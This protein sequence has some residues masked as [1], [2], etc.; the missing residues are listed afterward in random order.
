MD[1]V[2][3]GDRPAVLY[4]TNGSELMRVGGNALR[5]SAI[6]EALHRCA[7][8]TR[9]RVRCVDEEDC[10]H[11]APAEP[12][13]ASG[14]GQD[15]AF[16]NAYCSVAGQQ[17]RQVAE[18]VR[19]DIV[20]ATGLEMWRYL[21]A[22][23]EATGAVAV[24]DLVNADSQLASEIWAVLRSRPDAATFGLDDGAALRR[25]E[26]AALGFVDHLW[27]CTRLDAVALSG[28]HDFPIDNV[29]V[30]PNAVT[31]PA[32]RP[33]HSAVE[34]IVYLGRFGWFPNYLAAEFLIDELAPM[35]ARS[36]TALPI[37]LAG[38]GPPASLLDRQLPA[39]VRLL[40]DPVTIDHLWPDSLLAVP[41]TLGGGSRLKIL[42][43]FAAG[44]PVVSTAKGIEGIDAE[45]GVHYLRAETAAEMTAAISRITADH[46]LRENL[47]KAGFDLLN[48]AYTPQRL[49]PLVAGSLRRLTAVHH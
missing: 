13:A 10:A 12:P 9:H 34:R 28:L 15:A 39:A 38:F 20:V 31:S 1:S 46:T 2:S 16:H 36:A 8:T 4:L 43:A 5:T 7:A 25:V 30:V 37:V 3:T 29:T 45:D 42:E 23:K 6:D 32:V 33:Q 49:I 19:P 17:V 41:L 14:I 35:L 22:A 48:D 18:R 21:Y 44:C 40:A 24:L 26:A 11:A 47:T 27:T